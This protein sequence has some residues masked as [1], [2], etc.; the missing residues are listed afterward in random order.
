MAYLQEGEEFGS[1]CLH[2]LFI[3]FILDIP[4]PPR[5]AGSHL[6]CVA[7]IDMDTPKSTGVFWCQK[8][9]VFPLDAFQCWI[10]TCLAYLFHSTN[11]LEDVWD[12]VVREF[13]TRVCPYTSPNF[14]VWVP[15]SVCCMMY[16]VAAST[17]KLTETFWFKTL[18][19]SN[20]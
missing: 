17:W 6:L 5:R 20:V 7:V 14:Q 18:V 4:F 10:K 3:F 9:L 12:P 11:W 1:F 8:S 19:S 13:S 16:T 2:F 15:G